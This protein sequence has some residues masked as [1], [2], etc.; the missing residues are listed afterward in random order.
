MMTRWRRS[1]QKE[2]LEEDEEQVD[3][4][5]QQQQGGMP[6]AGGEAPLRAG[7]PGLR[8]GPRGRAR[9][10]AAE[11]GHA[12]AVA[13]PHAGRGGGMFDLGYTYAAIP[14]SCKDAYL[15]ELDWRRLMVVTCIPPGI[16][17]LSVAALLPESPVWLASS[18]GR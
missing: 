7:L 11:R 5:V 8:D 16:L 18:G 14:A 12:Q 10:G 1:R 15:V 17:G 13:H 9:D 4:E 3:Q 6:V 2:D